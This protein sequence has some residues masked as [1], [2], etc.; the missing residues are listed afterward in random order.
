[1]VQAIAVETKAGLSIQR[2]FSSEGKSPYEQIEYALRS[3]IIKEL[4]GKIVFE[5]HTVEAPK[6]WSQLATDILASKYFRKAGV[7]GTITET[8]IKQVVHRISHTIREFGEAHGYFLS[9]IDAQAFEDE[10]AFMLLT[11]RGAFNSPVWFNCGLFQQ[12]GITSSGGN[13]AW[14]FEANAVEKTPN[15]YE[16]PQCSAC[17]IQSVQDDLR[18]IFSLLNQEAIVFKYGSGTGTN[19]SRLRAKGEVLSGGG[20]S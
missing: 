11:Q 3:S 6:H 2:R 5:M 9:A 20:T 12:Y 7:P 19:F 1:M 14:N 17:F 18:S 4:D 13:F 8:S 16:R 10:L 15:A